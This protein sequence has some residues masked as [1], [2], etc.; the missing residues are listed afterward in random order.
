MYIEVVLKKKVEALTWQNIYQMLTE[1]FFILFDLHNYL[2][3]DSGTHE[4]SRKQVTD[5]KS[6]W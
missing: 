1:W 4:V 2:L 3:R 5:P 6:D